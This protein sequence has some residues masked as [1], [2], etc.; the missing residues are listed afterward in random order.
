MH[1]VAAAVGIQGGLALARLST[2]ALLPVFTMDRLRH[3]R[4]LASV[5]MMDL[6]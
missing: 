5:T 4:L 2:R 6:V 1:S 3:A